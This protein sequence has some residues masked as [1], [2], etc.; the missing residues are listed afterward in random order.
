MSDEIDDTRDETVFASDRLRPCALVRRRAQQRALV[1]D[2]VQ[3]GGQHHADQRHGLERW[4][5]LG[6]DEALPLTARQLA[7]QHV[8]QAPLVIAHG[9]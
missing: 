2:V 5:D 8:Q 6:P 7:L 3:R 9:P 1:A 4:I